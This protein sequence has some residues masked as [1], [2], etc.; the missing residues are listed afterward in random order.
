[1]L[2]F[3]CQSQ[4]EITEVWTKLVHEQHKR[5]ATSYSGDLADAK[6]AVDGPLLPGSHRLGRL[7]TVDLRPVWEAILAGHTAFE[8]PR[9]ERDTEPAGNRA[10]RA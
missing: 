7:R 1:V 3:G 5:A 2:L 8:R 4:T 6:W 9:Q 10:K